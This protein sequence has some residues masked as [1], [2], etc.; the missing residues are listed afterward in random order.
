MEQRI[1]EIISGHVDIAINIDAIKNGD[2]LEILGVN[3]IN[4]IRIVIDIESEFGIS[5]DVDYLGYDTYNDISSLVDYA[6]SLQ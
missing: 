3:S 4:F 6:K 1:K 5:F 2:P